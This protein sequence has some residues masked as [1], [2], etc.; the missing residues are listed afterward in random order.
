MEENITLTTEEITKIFELGFNDPVYFL[1]FHL[2]HL[3]PEAVPWFHRG[4]IAILTRK[5]DFLLKYGELDLIVQH[6]VWKED[7]ANPHSPEQPLFK[8][9]YNAVGEAISI[10]LEVTRF[11]E[12]II[13]RGFAKTTLIGIGIMIWLIEYQEC[14]FPLYVSETA[15]HAETQLRNVKNELEFNERLKL[16]FGTI[17]PGR[18]DRG[19][20]TDKFFETTT[21]ICCAAR[22]RGGQVRGLNV[23]G[24]RPDRVLCDDLEDEESIST[25]EQ[26]TKAVSWF[27]KALKPVIPR[28]D[29]TAQI[30]VLGTLLHKECLLMTL[31]NDPDWTT[32]RFG[33]IDRNGNPL[34]NLMMN[35]AAIDREKISYTKVGQLAAFYMEFLSIVR[36]DESAKFKER[37]IHH[38]PAPSENV[39]RAICI[40]PAI[41][42]K[43]GADGSSIAVVG[44]CVGGILPVL[45]SWYKVGATP[46]EQ[47]DKYF[48]FKLKWNCTHHGVEGIA[49]QAALI[50]LLKEE[51]HRRGCYFEIE[52]IRH[53]IKKDAR[54]LGILQPRYAAGYI[55]HTRVF[56][57]LEA[58]L[59]EYP[60]GKKDAPDAL[61]MAISLLDPVAACAADPEKDLTDDYFEPLGEWRSHR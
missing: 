47:V 28:L 40:D 55:I 30:M 48:E 60:Q 8:V 39:A 61:A 19:K 43:L 34:W 32:V 7:Q 31:A 36:N 17:A 14:K 20:W 51:M 56:A 11:S 41:S 4:I 26:R 49:Y 38:K 58:Q 50:H 10:D 25:P 18:S 15:L 1:K 6:F 23:G 44:M 21:G 35:L 59:L 37:Y 54:I 24:Q 29:P 33:A 52:N 16:I 27:Y 13:P 3:F 53:G 45:E 46:R 12:F 42:E 2:E 22:G 5:T 9:N 57:E